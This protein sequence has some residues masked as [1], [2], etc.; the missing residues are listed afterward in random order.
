MNGGGNR[1]RGAWW[2]AAAWTAGVLATLVAMPL[3][4]AGRL[5]DEMA[6]HWGSNGHPDD[7]MPFWAV[8]L[9]PAGLWAVTVLAL[10]LTVRWTGAAARS[11]AGVV[12]L[13]GGVLLT[14][15]QA[16][17][18]HANLD[19]TT[20]ADAAPVGFEVVV[21][22]AASA[23]AGLLGHLAG[24]RA[25]SAETART[26]GTTDRTADGTAGGP[27]EG[28]TGGPRLDVPAGER[29]AWLSRTVNPWLQLTATLFG[30]AATAGV[31]A[32]AAGL[33]D[34]LWAVA[35]ALAI[36]GVA[37]SACSTVQALVTPKGLEVAFGPFGWPVRRWHL[38]A[39]ESARSEQRTPAQV[40]GWG[41]RL[42]GLGTTV[43]LR[44]GDCLVVHPRKGSDF[45]VSVDD[46]ER[47]AALLNSMTAR[48]ADR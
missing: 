38:D 40:G 15:A 9:F 27:N 42:S 16:S 24:R 29:F 19:R 36:T 41:Y 1:I 21:V 25:T 12:L 37:V 31:G 46:A 33:A 2:S 28:T 6:T 3:A 7:S 32:A 5:P 48:P 13:S 22:L 39:I 11:W 8:P 26:G 30:L 18:V 45:A 10:A 17:I 23:A 20:W 43:M 47:G 44:R 34:V 14:G 35:P 4:A